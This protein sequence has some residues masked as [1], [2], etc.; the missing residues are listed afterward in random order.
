MADW[1]DK[2]YE[3]DIII[4]PPIGILNTRAI[5]KFKLPIPGTEHVVKKPETP[6]G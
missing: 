2:Y 1:V 6:N 3:P 5:E 4:K